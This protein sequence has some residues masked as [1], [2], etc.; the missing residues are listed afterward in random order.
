MEPL[1][2][3]TDFLERLCREYLNTFNM[4][5]R[6]IKDLANAIRGTLVAKKVGNT[7]TSTTKTGRTAS[8]P[9]PTSG[10]RT[11]RLSDRSNSVNFKNGSSGR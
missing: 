9:A 2:E 4:I 10:R 8:A 6:L 1:Y 7:P 3:R 11:G 5:R